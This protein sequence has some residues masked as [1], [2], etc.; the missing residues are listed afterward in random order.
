M[1]GPTVVMGFYRRIPNCLSPHCCIKCRG[2]GESSDH[3][4]V[5]NPIVLSLGERCL[6]SWIELGCFNIFY[7]IILWDAQGFWGRQYRCGLCFWVVWL[8]RNRRILVFSLYL[9]LAWLTAH[10]NINTSDMAWKVWIICCCI[11]Q[12]LFLYVLVYSMKKVYV[13]L[14]RCRIMRY[15]VRSLIFLVEV[16]YFS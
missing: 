13:G 11:A 12:W 15:Y 1:V 3:L 6:G 4:C 9:W 10:G 5:H 2:E 8:D 14:S 16:K 7:S